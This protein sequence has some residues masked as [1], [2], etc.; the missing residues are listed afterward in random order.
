MASVP[1]LA[2][3]V[4]KSGNISL[5]TRFLVAGGKGFPNHK[6]KT[7]SYMVTP[8]ELTDLELDAV[9][10]GVLE[11][12]DALVNVGIVL[13]ERAVN[14][15]IDIEVRQIQVAVIALG[16]GPIEFADQA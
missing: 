12:G 13:E 11:Q 3:S 2:R 6:E 14:I 5:V 7:M 4:K 8:V 10:G 15:P 1:S 16:R 9:A